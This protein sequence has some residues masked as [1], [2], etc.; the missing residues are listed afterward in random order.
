MASS[1]QRG[2]Q[3]LAR[4]QSSFLLW[5]DLLLVTLISSPSIA[6]TTTSGGLTGVV[7]DPSGAV[8]FDA[9]V[10]IRN[11]S[12]GT[13]QSLKTDRGGA[14]QFSFL[15]PAR[16]TLT[17]VHAG[18]QTKN[19][20]VDVL[21][22]PP[23]TVNVALR[24][25]QAT[26][27]VSV[28]AEAPLVH[29]ENGDVSTTMNQQQ[30]SE[31]PNPGND[32]TYI[33][34]T[35]PGAIM[36]TD[37]IGFGGSGNFSILGMPGTSNLFTLN[38]MNDNNNGPNINN[39]VTANTNNSG[40]TGMMLGQNE[41]QEATVVSD[42]YSGQF[43]GAA[44]SSI[45]YL[46]KSGGNTLQG[47]PTQ[48]TAFLWQ[49]GAMQDLGT[50]GGTDA[51]AFNIN[52]GGQVSGFSY[53]N[54]DATL[55]PFFWQNGTMTDIGSLGGTFGAPNGM[56]SHGQVVGISNL[57]GDGNM[58]PF[59]WDRGV[60]TDLG[61]FGGS[62][63]EADWISD[64]GAVVGKADFAGDFIHHAFVWKNGVMTDVGV[65]PGDLCTNGSHINSRGQAIGTSTNCMGV[66]QHVFLW[67]NGSIFDLGA[68]ILGGT[69]IAFQEAFD[70]NDRGEIAAVG[71]LP[72][73]DL[74]AVLLVPASENEI[75][76]AD[77]SSAAKAAPAAP[78][79]VVTTSRDSAF[80]GRNGASV[81]GRW[82]RR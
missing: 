44:G 3:T 79:R 61:T 72:N 51:I 59:F 69:D 49:N 62:N 82:T 47:F 4:L 41:I 15:A 52:N 37:A 5:L 24:V 66:V 33:V 2:V 58:H 6:Q 70:I 40:V 73:G 18:F 50:L 7:T 23:V 28:T 55:N 10:E 32:L 60:L 16:Y 30:V 45:N 57:A 76:A 39:N 43:G 81:S 17:V 35:A 54:S 56:N 63:G 68:L 80:G 20:A 21:L 64:S 67:E 9:D 38:G 42:G 13:N 14:Y 25:A 78:H 22:G 53:T 8:V 34:Q 75:A 36:N 19:R 74:R 48:T 26:T 77:A 46:T 11:T 1:N 31:V 12:K 71:M 65:V 27:T 29:A